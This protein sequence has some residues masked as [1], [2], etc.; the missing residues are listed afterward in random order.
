MPHVKTE[1]KKYFHVL[2][3]L[4]PNQVRALQLLKVECG[5]TITELVTRQVEKLLEEGDKTKNHGR[6]ND[7]AATG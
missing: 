2:L 4:R 1:K 6:N 7:T 5:I 3:D